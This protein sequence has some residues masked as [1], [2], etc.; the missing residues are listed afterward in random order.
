MK[1]T[2]RESV[3]EK[4]AFIAIQ[5]RQTDTSRSKVERPGVFHP[6]VVHASGC[7]REM[8][9]R[10]FVALVDNHR[11]LPA[12]TQMVFSGIH[13]NGEV[14]IAVRR[15][16]PTAIYAGSGG[17]FG[18]RAEIRIVLDEKHQRLPR[19][20]LSSREIRSFRFHLEAG[21]DSAATRGLRGIRRSVS[22]E[23][24]RCE[25]EDCENSF[26]IG[27]LQGRRTIK[28]IHSMRYYRIGKCYS[29]PAKGL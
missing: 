10:G 19:F 23:N 5:R 9:G 13:G 8:G 22:C 29:L 7:R 28:D 11:R 21:V 14:R 2:E 1:S 27:Y 4:L 20:R 6:E 3:Q 25:Q 24:W 16:H 18:F 15:S 26:H 12:R 17:W